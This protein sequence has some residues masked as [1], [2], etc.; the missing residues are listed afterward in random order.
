[1]FSAV[2]SMLQLLSSSSGFIHLN[3]LPVIHI[4]EWRTPHFTA[5]CPSWCQPS[6]FI[7][8]LGPALREHAIH[9][10][11]GS[12]M[13]FS[14]NALNPIPFFDPVGDFDASY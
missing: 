3:T 14:E 7:P 4:L 11:G 5:G 6:H 13:I 9:I 10:S 1:M 8:G 12:I 2:N